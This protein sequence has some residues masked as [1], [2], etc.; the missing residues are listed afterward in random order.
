MLPWNMYSVKL[1]CI[2]IHS[3]QLHAVIQ[4]TCLPIPFSVHPL[5]RTFSHIISYEW[6]HN[7]SSTNTAITAIFLH[8][9]Q[10]YSITSLCWPCE[11]GCH[12]PQR[13]SWNVTH[14]PPW[15]HYP[16]KN[17]TYTIQTMKCLYPQLCIYIS[18]SHFSF[19]LTTFFF[20]FSSPFID[21]QQLATILWCSKMMKNVIKFG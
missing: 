5:D 2:W 16:S 12:S 20:F 9:I 21:L 13:A 17:M 15:V 19:S 18:L 6:V 1:N 14:V 3:L 7:T 8:H 10:S 4:F 11:A